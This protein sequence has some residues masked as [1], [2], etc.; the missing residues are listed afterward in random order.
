MN[1]ARDLDGTLHLFLYG[2][3]R[4]TENGVFVPSKK[5]DKKYVMELPKDKYKKITFDNSPYEYELKSKTKDLITSLQD[6]VNKMNETGISFEELMKKNDRSE[7][8][9]LYFYHGNVCY[10]TMN[11][12]PT[13][14]WKLKEIVH[15]DNCHINHY[16]YE[17]KYGEVIMFKDPT[18]FRKVHPSDKEYEENIW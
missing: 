9:G 4:D 16:T 18:D 5:E 6:A 14:Y 1:V 15:Y 3:V 7:V 2:C 13:C 10:E 17:N 8:G 12:K 11:V